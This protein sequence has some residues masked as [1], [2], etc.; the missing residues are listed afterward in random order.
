[1]S[2]KTRWEDKSAAPAIPAEYAKAW[3]SF[4]RALEDG[5]G[6]KE[7]VSFH[8]TMRDMSSQGVPVP[9][10]WTIV[11]NAACSGRRVRRS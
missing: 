5:L 7:M 4:C 8:K 11:Y 1:M 3:A 10:E 6:D 2:D 9:E